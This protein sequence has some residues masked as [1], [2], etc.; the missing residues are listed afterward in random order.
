M[1]VSYMDETLD[2]PKLFTSCVKGKLIGEARGDPKNP[3]LKS[4]LGLAF[5]VE[6]QTKTIAEMTTEEYD[7]YARSDRWGELAEFLKGR[8]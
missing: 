5:I 1:T 8:K 4:Q 2:K 7:K 6:G 3:N